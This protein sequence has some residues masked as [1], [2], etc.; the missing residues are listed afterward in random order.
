MLTIEKI[1]NGYILTE[2]RFEADNPRVWIARSYY[3]ISDVVKAY[4]KDETN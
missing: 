1:E 2:K 4:F 3:D